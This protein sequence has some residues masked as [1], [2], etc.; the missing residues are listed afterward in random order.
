MT[1]TT[2]VW[3][4]LVLVGIATGRA[5]AEDPWAQGV[6][7]DKKAAAQKLLEAGNALFLEKKYREALDQYTAAIHEWD[8][9]A[10][11]FNIV[12]CYIFLEKPVEAS[13][14]LE[15]ALKYGAAPLEDSVYQEALSYQALLA[16]QVGNLE[17]ACDQAG[18]KVTLDGQPLIATCPGKETRRLAIGQHEVVGTREGFLTETRDVV[19]VGG[20][21]PQSV[22]VKL[23]PLAKA[24]KVVHKW[25][26]WKP[27]LVFGG[28]LALVAVGGGLDAIASSQM[29]T[30]DNNLASQCGTTGCNGPTSQ[31]KISVSARDS[32]KLESRIGVGV[33]AVGAAATVT[34]AVL[35]YVNRSHTVYEHAMVTPTA[36]G[37]AVSFGGTF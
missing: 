21:K 16:K 31:Q 3:C 36:G 33:L 26:T 35:L 24:A 5:R 9:P 6:P 27:W 10:I 25:A 8:H 4:A 14:H 17:V 12:R 19:V 20:D 22:D 13:E 23:V 28:G 1:W 11:E 18:T 29:S 37:A 30:F 32:A 15:V 7:Q 34:G 2:R